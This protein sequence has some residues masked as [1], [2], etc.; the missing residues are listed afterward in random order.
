MTVLMNPSNALRPSLVKLARE[1]MRLTWRKLWQALEPE[2]R[3][4]GID[5]AMREDKGI[6]NVMVR[7]V[8]RSR[9]FRPRTVESWTD[10]KIAR[11]A[12]K[13]EITD[14]EAIPG[15]LMWLHFSSR[16]A[17]LGR[18]L[19]ALQISHSNGRIDPGDL[20]AHPV[21][22]ARLADAA[23][24]LVEEFSANEVVAYLLTLSL[25]GDGVWEGVWPWLRQY[26][27]EEIDP[28]PDEE[29]SD[30]VASDQETPTADE[31]TTLDRR[32][33]H[34]VIDVAQGIEG[35]A[36]EDE[37]DDLIDEIIQLNSQ[38]HRTY[39]H[40]G[41]RDSV[42][43]RGPMTTLS[44]ENRDR[45]RWYWAG[46]VQ[47]LVRLDDWN[48]VVHAFDTVDAVREL[49]DSGEGAS[50]AA[51]RCIVEAL[52]K[53]DRP[54]DIVTFIRL[55]AV[56]R[57]RPMLATLLKEG[58]ELL[59]QDRATEARGLFELLGN[60]VER[61]EAMGFDTDAAL[62]QA[63][64]R[65]RANCL[66]Q[67]GEMETATRLLE[68]LLPRAADDIKS[69]I[70]ADLGLIAAG[71]HRL[72]DLVMPGAADGLA[73]FKESLRRGTGFFHE[74]VAFPGAAAGHG[75]YC[76]GLLALAEGRPK[77][78]VEDL[79]LALSLFESDAT[80]YRRGGLLANARLYLGIALCQDL[81]EGRLRR[82]AR[83]IEEGLDEGGEIPAYCLEDVMM[84]LGV[85]CDD[86]LARV[87][88][89]LLT[90]SD[91]A[92]L[93]H[94]IAT[95][96]T[97]DSKAVA[98]ALLARMRDSSRGK[99]A[100]AADALDLLPRLLKQERIDDAAEV[101]TFLEQS[102]HHGTRRTQFLALLDEPAA[103]EPAWEFEDALWARIKCHEDEGEYHEAAHLLTNEFYR[104]TSSGTPG[105]LE[106]SR[107]ILGR[108]ETYPDTTELLSALRGRFE[109][110]H[111][112]TA[113]DES[114]EAPSAA[115]V[116]VLVV[117]GDE[118]QEVYD[119][120]IRQ[121]LRE[122]NIAV[123]FVHPGW[124]SNWGRTMSDIKRRLPGY[125]AVVVM[126]LVRTTFG[127][128][129]RS[130]C[131]VWHGCGGT[132]RGSIVRSIQGAAAMARQWMA[133]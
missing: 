16:Q 112:V 81:A 102:A 18:F 23:N 61:L 126:R 103:Y 64:R 57:S 76:L 41:L 77:D 52:I 32:M 72:A 43:R 128:T 80:T 21:A 71:F 5:A 10:D 95:A 115:L 101:L 25:Q 99:D 20:P 90:H 37:L 109:A 79:T 98:S 117:G 121:E 13:I 54:T 132:G 14:R 94:L 86:L 133:A 3:Y 118:R 124:S 88:E 84:A 40:A 107:E 27:E 65:R 42:L 123:D 122:Q 12:S 30:P 69:M 46:F 47:G 82:A 45:R 130:H 87:A 119:D 73:E 111:G 24:A 49:G 59:R 63:I 34:V 4:T 22:T 120:T 58:T 33:I 55:P 48:A 85:G 11:F 7:E 1:P 104:L 92:V 2:E 26:G 38:R 35:A 28:V 15:L 105:D 8:A 50:S 125:D 75:R 56:V 97:Q 113:P 44:A 114:V 110:V 36:S 131:K 66:R 62:F 127:W 70:K 116:K 68:E 74:A 19:D 17:L 89:R 39:F 83:L 96:A 53:A 67:L 9:H 6:R 31:F 108:L 78:A 91:P 29:S 51:S 100:R 106:Q 60:A 93:D 129:L